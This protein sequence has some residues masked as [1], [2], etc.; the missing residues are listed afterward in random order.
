[1]NPVF[2]IDPNAGE[3]RSCSKP[4]ECGWGDHYTTAAEARIAYEA[5]M[6]DFLFVVHRRVGGSRRDGGKHITEL[7]ARV[8]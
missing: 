5:I 1:M 3:P 2:H 7:V 4:R 8:R 6:S